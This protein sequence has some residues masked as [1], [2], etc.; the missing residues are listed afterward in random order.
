MASVDGLVTGMSTTE[1]IAQLMQVEAAP[2]AALK[3]KITAAN[4]VV[5]AYQSISSRMSA[6]TSAAKVL[7]DPNTWGSLKATSSSEAAVASTQAGA[8]PG[9]VSFHVTQLATTRVDVYLGS[10]VSSLTDANPFPPVLAGTTIGV[11]LP[12]PPPVGKTLTPADG[13]LQSVISAI[14]GEDKLPYRASAVPTAQGQYTLQITAKESG[15]AGA[16]KVDAVGLPTGLA[17]TGVDTTVDA[18]EAV[19][20]VASPQAGVFF[21]VTSSSNNFTNVLPGVTITAAKLT[22]PSTDPITITMTTDGEGMAAKVQTL[23]DN[24]NAALTEIAA[25]SKIKSGSAAAGALAGDSAMRKLTQDI[26]AT[27]S[28]GAEALGA[29]GSAGSYKDI[30]IGIDRY[31]KLTFKKEDFIKAYENDSVK[32]QKFFSEYKDDSGP[33]PNGKFDPGF[34]KAIGLARKLEALSLIATEGVI[35]PQFPEKGKQGILQGL[36]QRRNDN[37]R[38]LND[39]VNQWDLRLE[40]R[41]TALQKQFSSLEVAMGKMQQQS[42]WLASQLA[43][44]G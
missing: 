3:T 2:Q 31:G 14:N 41:K 21:D 25:Q 7:N 16:A 37:I 12:G 13:S 30:G 8:V 24:A 42:S 1:T 18:V 33:V 26:L 35:N 22:D 5:T 17:L 10:A 36:I 4:R 38:G 40:L 39:Q 32:T 19:L 29:N 27:I 15:P 11:T 20:S 23:I 28:G 34:D 9:T 6:I 43:G 44:L